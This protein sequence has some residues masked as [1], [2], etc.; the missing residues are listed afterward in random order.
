MTIC[1]KILKKKIHKKL[2]GEN[3]VTRICVK[4]KTSEQ[5]SAP[6]KTILN[7]LTTKLKI[8]PFHTYGRRYESC[9]SF[10]Q[11]SWYPLSF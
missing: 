7:Q 3:R 8:L 5:S 4:S 1:S 2:F 6:K 10:F 11:R 9:S